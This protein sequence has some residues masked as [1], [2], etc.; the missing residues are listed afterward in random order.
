M[1]NDCVRAVTEAAIKAGRSLTATDLAGIEGR[2]RQ[3]LRDNARENLDA[4]RAMTPAEQVS[5]AADRVAKDIEFEHQRAAANVARQIIAHDRNQGFVDAQA[6]KGMRRT[7]AVQH[8]IFNFLTG[9]GGFRTLEQNLEG[10]VRSAKAKM[11]P[12]AQA[13]QRFLGFWTDK[14]RVRNIVRELYGE[15]THD[16]QAREVAKI[17]SDQ[18]AEPLRNQFNELGGAIRKLKGW[19]VPQDHSMWKVNDGTANA[20]NNWIDYVLPR[21]DRGQYVKAN[22]DMMSESD[23]RALLAESWLSITT[24]GAWNTRP[25]QNGGSLRN[26]GQERRVLHFKDADSYLDYQAK[27]GERSLLETMNSHIEG[28]GKNIAALQTLGPQAEAGL[29][30][31][32][33]DAVQ[34]D[35]AAGMP[36]DD[37][38]KAR[39]KAEIGFALASGKMGQMG[40]P[41]VSKWYQTAR[42]FLSAARLGSASLSALTDSSNGIAVARAWNIPAIAS[43]AKWESKAWS[44]QEFRQ[45]M[46]SQGVG[47]EA[48]T[49]AISRYGE[50]VFGHGFSSNLANTVFRVSGLNLID[51]VRRVATGAMLFD[52]IGELARTHETLDAAHPDDVARL[53]NAGVD[54]KTWE[55]WRQAAQEAGEGQMITP[56]GIARLANRSDNVKR[57]A[58]QALVGAVSRDIDTVVPMPTLKARSSIEYQLAGL[59]GKPGGELARSILQFKSFPLAMISNHWQRLQSMPTPVGKAIYAAELIATSTLL[60]AVSIQLKSLVAGNNPQDMKDPKFAARAF[61]QGG[62]TGLYG[63]MIAG[64]SAISPY[65]VSL[66]DQLG[67]LASTMSDA[68]DLSRTAW[69]SYADPEKKANLGGEATR[70]IKGNTPFANVWWGKAAIDHLIFQRLQDYYSPGYADRMQQRTQKFYNSGQWWR[71][72]TA[73]SPA[74]VITSTKGITTPR[75]P[76]LTTAVGGGR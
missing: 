44:D 72:S 36:K 31:L 12:I 60:G 8:I 64:L 27:Y 42:S 52:R 39:D 66:P 74:Q 30:A 55:V 37:A 5:A 9:K 19:A 23:M 48:I 54:A 71:P 75:A 15:D 13:T 32:L 34:K 49:H 67:P 18:I 33:D 6:A 16:S 57:D 1:R 17:W 43:W 7:D 62:A 29:K 56:A 26:R 73:A 41:R 3:A 28:M 10:V 61:V 38:Q 65:K 21:L 53:R 45:F 40:D 50:E 35:T 20:T 51:N 22:G 59:R 2:I 46:R 63:D 69:N 76:D 68:Y 70:F 14:A 25:G 4:H 11:E 58:M 24:D 47:V